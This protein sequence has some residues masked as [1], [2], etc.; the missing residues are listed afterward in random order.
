M[1]ESTVAPPT[2]CCMNL[3]LAERRWSSPSP[4]RTRRPANP[5]AAAA[6]LGEGARSA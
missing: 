5:V 1:A 6:V 3:K 4:K 2:S